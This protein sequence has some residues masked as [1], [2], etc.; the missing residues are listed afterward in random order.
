MKNKNLLLGSALSAGVLLFSLSLVLN[1]KAHYTP[2]TN[3]NSSDIE[4]EHDNGYAGAAKWLFDIQKNPSTGTIDPLDVLN[5]REEVS[6]M[7]NNRAA[8]AS[9]GLD[10]MELGPDNVGG[11]TRAILIDKNNNNKIFAGSVS[12]GLWVSTNGGSNWSNVAGFDQQP[13]LAIVSLV[14]AVNGDI[15]AGTGEGDFYYYTGDGSAGILGAG[16]YKSTDDGLTFTRLTS[17]IPTT[18]NSSSSGTSTAFC[19]VHKLAV[20]PTDPNRIYAATKY[21]LQLSTD[22]GLTWTHPVL[23]GNGS[24]NVNSSLDVEVASNGTVIANINNQLYRSPSGDAGTYTHITAGLPASGISRIA[25]AI[26]PTDPNYMYAL[27]GKQTNELLLGVYQSIDNGLNWSVI[28]SGGSSQFEPFGSAGEAGQSSYDCAIAVFPAD[29]TKIIIGGVSIWTWQQTNPAVPGIGQWNEA[30]SQF[31]S[32]NNPYYVH[33]DVHEIKFQPSNSSVFYIGCDGG[34]FRGYDG[35]N[36]MGTVFQPMNKGY[37]VTQFYGIAFAGDDPARIAFASGAQDNGTQYVSGHGNTPKAAQSIGGGDGAESEI[38]F[39][40]PNVSFSTVYYG[41]LDRHS[42]KGSQGSSFYPAKFSSLFP[43]LGSAGFAS[44]VTPIA[45]YE[46]KTAANSPDFASFINQ[47]VGQI[48]GT[49]NGIDKHFTGHLNLPQASASIVPDSIIIVS[50]LQ[51][52]FDNGSG[53]LTGAVD[54]TKPHSINYITGAYDF[55]FAA[56]PA[57]SAPVNITFDVQYAPGS[58]IDIIRPSFVYPLNYVT[59]LADG[60]VGPGDTLKIYDPFQ[61]K[62]AVGFS[63]ASGIWM[64]KE[65]LNFTASARWFKIGAAAGEAEKLAWSPDGDILYVGDNSGNLYR[66]SH[67]AAVTD[68]ANGDIASPGCVV[69]KTQIANFGSY[70]TGISVDPVDAN[71]VAVSLGSY[72]TGTPVHIYYSS[73]AATCAANTSTTNFSGKQGTGASKLPAMPV[74]T[75]LIELTDPKRV[76]VGTEYGVYSTPDITVANPVWSADNGV[77]G[78]F[79][80]V[81]VFK[82]RQQRLPGSAVYNPSVIYAASH[83]RGAWKCEN[84][85]GQVTVGINEPAKNISDSKMDSGISVYPNPM[86]DIGTIQFNLGVAA[87]VTISVYNLEGKLIKIIKT[88]RLNSGEQKIPISSEEFSK[89]TYL[90]SID[91]TNIH[92][93]SKFV[94]V[95]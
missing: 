86:N 79:P 82:L 57:A 61:A 81:P 64:T 28:G 25:F 85:L 23:L 58:A 48:A 83:G 17:T 35:Y 89:G 29:K 66:F 72:G 71:K 68:S 37:N 77:T 15:Y 20:S 4:K 50:G 93:S 24:P 67:L 65:A 10:W 84:Y 36:G 6:Q 13:N 2:R 11:R 32:A 92:A 80:N 27:A 45:L 52:V 69:V 91:G 1:N 34:I 16:I 21:G 40:N 76:I 60:T 49:G 94:V 33:S 75:A 9:L 8:N 95:K 19:S 14:Q 90:V 44:F 63:G 51:K 22:A 88:E 53:S 87:N 78:L 12:G 26:S 3:N 38:S 43:S 56:A 31:G 7:F 54:L 46:T 59:T 41:T 62:I 70:I 55:Y 42:S 74:Y 39:L 18:A 47:P 5:A 30:T 73:T